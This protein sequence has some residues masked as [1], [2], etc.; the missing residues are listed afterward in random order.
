MKK[1]LKKFVLS[2]LLII[3]CSGCATST[4]NIPIETYK[5]SPQKGFVFGRFSFSLFKTMWQKETVVVK[6]DVTQEKYIL[7]VTEKNGY[8]KDRWLYLAKDIYWELEPASYT[9]TDIYIVDASSKFHLKPEIEFKILPNTY[10]YIGTLHFTQLDYNYYVVI[11]QIKYNFDIKDDLETA[12]TAFKEAR[13]NIEKKDIT[14]SLMAFPKNSTFG[15]SE[16]I[17]QKQ[18]QA[19]EMKALEAPLPYKSLKSENTEFL[20]RK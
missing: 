5:L 1:Y 18:K 4:P 13:V 14:T 11:D 9:I 6:N 10:N 16:E 20:P 3:L 7:E 15:L 19:E 8:A 12:L 2:S 17:Q